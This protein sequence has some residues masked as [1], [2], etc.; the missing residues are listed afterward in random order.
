VGND[1]QPTCNPRY[2]LANQGQTSSSPLLHSK[3]SIVSAA[4]LEASIVG[5]LLLSILH[6]QQEVIME[7]SQV[8]FMRKKKETTQGGASIHNEGMRT[9]LQRPIQCWQVQAPSHLGIY[10]QI[11]E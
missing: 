7:A 2:I 3:G 4:P 9:S 8:R 5:Q 10:L 6:H 1:P 11:E